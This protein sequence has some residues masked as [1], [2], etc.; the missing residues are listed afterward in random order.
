MSNELALLKSKL[1]DFLQKE[2][3]DYWSVHI[4]GSGNDATLVGKYAG[5]WRFTVE[6]DEYFYL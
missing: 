6:Y 5:E 2:I 1:E 4:E 3:D